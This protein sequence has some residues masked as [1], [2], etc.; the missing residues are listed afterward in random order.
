MIIERV[1]KILQLKLMNKLIHS[2][3]KKLQEKFKISKIFNFH[4]S[5]NISSKMRREEAVSILLSNNM[6]IMSKIIIKCMM[7]ER[8]NFLQTFKKPVNQ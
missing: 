4:H 6:E 3:I 7:K 1:I 8:V 2:K 5:I